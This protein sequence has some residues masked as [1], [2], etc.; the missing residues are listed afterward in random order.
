MS[1]NIDF[2]SRHVGVSGRD[3]DAMIKALGYERI[4]DLIDQA[5]PSNIRYDEEMNL[6]EALSEVEH[7]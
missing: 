7:Y 1:P 4:M 3:R 5:V 2:C 6:P